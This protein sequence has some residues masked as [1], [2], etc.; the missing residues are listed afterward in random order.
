MKTY[1]FRCHNH[2][3]RISAFD[4]DK[5]KIANEKPN[6]KENNNRLTIYM[7]FSR[8]SFSYDLKIVE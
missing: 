8:D 6:S 2:G 7:P 3:T 5:N 4:F 1:V